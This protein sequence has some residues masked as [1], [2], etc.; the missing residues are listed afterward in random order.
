M[1]I[2]PCKIRVQESMCRLNC[3]S[4]PWQTPV[5]LKHALAVYMNTTLT[6]ARFLKAVSKHFC[7]W[8]TLTQ[9]HLNCLCRQT[10]VL[11]CPKNKTE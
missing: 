3:Q 10:L 11:Q 5:S 4:V 6:V 9:R 1:L 7:E 8:E 2:F